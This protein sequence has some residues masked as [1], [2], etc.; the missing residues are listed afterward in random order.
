MCDELHVM[1]DGDQ[2]SD[3]DLFR[4]ARQGEWEAFDALVTRLEPRVFAVAMR[5]LRQR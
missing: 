5:L 1:D 2:V 4:R 3:L